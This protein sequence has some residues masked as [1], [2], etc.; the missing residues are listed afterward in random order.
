MGDDR[1]HLGAAR[2]HGLRKRS[3]GVAAEMLLGQGH[4]SDFSDETINAGRVPSRKNFV[5][6]KI[7]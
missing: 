2:L 1:A 3:A 4:G 5:R 7:V 6:V